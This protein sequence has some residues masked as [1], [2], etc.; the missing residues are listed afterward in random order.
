M[1]CLVT[2]MIVAVAWVAGVVRSAPNLSDLTPRAPHSPTAIYAADGSLLG[3]VYSGVVSDYLAPNQIPNTLKEATVA[4]ED[5]R[6]W[7]HGAVDY[8]SIIRAGVR[9]LLTGGHSLQ[10]ASTLTMQL[11]DNM[12]LPAKYSLHRGLSTRSSRSS[13]P[14][15]CN[16]ATPRAGSSTCT[17]MTFRTAR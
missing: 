15:N 14:S 13:S 11:V 16:A 6:F 8:E 9:D 2:A 17:S 1:T 12:Y 3:Y 4:I 5:R 7:H 10:G